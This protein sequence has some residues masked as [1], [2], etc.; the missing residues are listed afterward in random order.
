VPG[1]ASSP[2]AVEVQIGGL[3]TQA[4]AGVEQSNSFCRRAQITH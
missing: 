2:L 3:I 4:M 1:F